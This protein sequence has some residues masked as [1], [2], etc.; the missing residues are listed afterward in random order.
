M[1]E[2]RES[3]GA[4]RPERER[5]RSAKVPSHKTDTHALEEL[6]RTVLST[7]QTNIEERSSGGKR[8]RAKENI[9]QTSTNATQS[10]ERVSQGLSGVREAAKKRRQERLTALLHHVNVDLL[11]DGYYALKRPVAPRVDGVTWQEYETGLENRLTDLHNRVHRGA[12]RANLGGRARFRGVFQVAVFQ[13]SSFF[14]SPVSESLI[15]NSPPSIFPSW[16]E[17]PVYPPSC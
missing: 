15:L 5:G 1:H 16:M 10:G 2:N 8:V 7:N 11:R 6:D 3:S 14:H 17:I 12:Y 4:P 9:A 13:S